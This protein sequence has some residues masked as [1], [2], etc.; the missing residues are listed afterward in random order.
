MRKRERNRIDIIVEINITKANF[1]KW[2][3]TGDASCFL[4][5]ANNTDKETGSR[6]EGVGLGL[7]LGSC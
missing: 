6:S 2:P 1:T 7:Y 3:K 4:N 5:A